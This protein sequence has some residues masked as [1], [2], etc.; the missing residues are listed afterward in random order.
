[1]RS[2]LK[3]QTKEQ[4]KNKTFP[5]EGRNGLPLKLS[6]LS[7]FTAHLLQQFLPGHCLFWHVFLMSFSWRHRDP[8]GQLFPRLASR[9]DPILKT[10]PRNFNSVP[11]A[12]HSY[13]TF[14]VTLVQLPRP[15]LK[16][17]TALPSTAAG[18]GSTRHHLVRGWL[19][20]QLYRDG[21]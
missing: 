1:M 11:R 15:L 14:L 19:C 4:L 18:K 13:W 5:F 2:C 20:L 17:T 7:V 12:F 3:S 10:R 16:D 6:S 21:G 8:G 9:M